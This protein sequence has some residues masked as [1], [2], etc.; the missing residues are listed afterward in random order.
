MSCLNCLKPKYYTILLTSYINFNYSFKIEYKHLQLLK[1]KIDEIC[2]G[3]WYKGVKSDI[4]VHPTN[5]YVIKIK[6][7]KY[8]DEITDDLETSLEYF[9][10]GF[11]KKEHFFKYRR[12]LHSIKHNFYNH[13]N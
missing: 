13:V 4:F 9:L 8:N 5:K 12:C 10:E 6:G 3:N 2:N 11:Y 1:T 7:D